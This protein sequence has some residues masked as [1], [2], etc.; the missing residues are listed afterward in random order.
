M[1]RK[2]LVRLKREG[3][4]ADANTP[5]QHHEGEILDEV[6]AERDEET[7]EMVVDEARI[8][9]MGAVDADAIRENRR[10]EDVVNKK[11]ANVKHVTFNT[12]D[13]IA[14]YDAII[15]YWP[16]N[17]LDISVQ[18]LTGT[19]ITQVITSQPASGVELYKAI[20][21]IHGRHEEATYSVR[22][23][24]NNKKEHRGSGKVT[25]PDARVSSTADPPQ[26]QGQPMYNYPPPPGYLPPGYPPGYSPTQAPPGYPPPGY[27]V[28]QQPT[29]AQPQQMPQQPQ[30]PVVVHAPPGPDMGALLE[31]FRQVFE[32]FQ[33]MQQRLAPPPAAPAPAPAAPFVMP[34]QPGQDLTSMLS[35]L[36][37]TLEVFQQMVPQGAATPAP[38]QPIAPG[39]P[40]PPAPPVT[41]PPGMVY[42]PPIGYVSAEWVLQLVRG[43]ALGAPPPQSENPRFRPVQREG[44]GPP[45]DQQ[46]PRYGVTPQ[47]GRR[48]Y[49]EQPPYDP[50]VQQQQQ[51]PRG[52]LDQFRESLTVLRSAQQMINELGGMFGDRPTVEQPQQA[53][54]PLPQQDDD[55]PIQVIDTGAAKIVVNRD[56]GSLRGFETMWSNMPEILKWGGEQID[57]VRRSQ[58]ERTREQQQAQ[59]PRFERP[60][61]VQSLPLVVVTPDYRPPPGFVP[62]AVDPDTFE[63]G[64]TGSDYQ[65][66][67][68]QYAQSPLPPMPQDLPP[69]IQEGAPL[70]RT[71]DVTP[72]PGHNG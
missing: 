65:P 13:L 41:P 43:S 23:Y 25:I 47:Y 51:Q 29:A 71:W 63:P 69:P 44:Y 26:P 31:N 10:V 20:Q 35:S 11:R 66:P 5:A 62:V 1:A 28:A 40:L 16:P 14:K 22:F 24:D 45:R 4:G 42:L 3:V 17:T 59:T 48:P 56:D 55:S 8:L 38:A 7:G 57:R 9:E 53:A 39:T 61:A 60:R 2:R 6:G 67:P 50:H 32:T 58:E 18:R 70:R 68:M 27:P 36:R 34:P 54:E 33:G 46:Q 30:Q 19:P 37:Q 72:I 49:E 15:K 12:S 21:L 52:G 64:P